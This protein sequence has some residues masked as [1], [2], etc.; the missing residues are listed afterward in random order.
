MSGVSTNLPPSPDGTNHPAG[1]AGQTT[2]AAASANGSADAPGRSARRERGGREQD[3]GRAARHGLEVNPRRRGSARRRRRSSSSST[4]SPGSSGVPA[5]RGAA[6]TSRS[7]GRRCVLRAACATSSAHGCASPARSA[8]SRSSPLTRATIAP[9]SPANSSG[10]TTTGPIDVAKSVLFTPGR[11]AAAHTFASEKP[12]IAPSAPIIAASPSP[13]RSSRDPAG[14]GDVGVRADD[15]GRVPERE[16]ELPERREHPQPGRREHR[17]PELDVRERILG[18]LARGGA[19]A[20]ERLQRL[21]RELDDPI[22]VDPPGPAALERRFRRREHAE[23]HAGPAPLVAAA[24][25]CGQGRGTRAR[26]DPH[27]GWGV[28]HPPPTMIVARGRGGAQGVLCNKCV[29]FTA[30]CGRS[31][32]RSRVGHGGFSPRSRSRARVPPPACCAGRGRA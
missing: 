22:A 16:V 5:A 19:A 32:R 14:H 15:R 8:R 23:L 31:R 18:V 3:P 26:A 28:G 25:F 17:R 27:P 2:P 7:P 1:A 21:R 9:R 4:T 13:W 20:E 10:V 6:A 11:S 30:R 12:P 29:N 24:S